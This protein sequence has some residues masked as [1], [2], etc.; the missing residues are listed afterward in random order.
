D[1]DAALIAYFRSEYAPLM[2]QIDETGDYNKDIEAA[3]KAGIESFK[4]TQTY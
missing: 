1:F 4:A 3:I 2:K